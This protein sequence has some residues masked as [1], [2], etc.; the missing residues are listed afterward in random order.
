MGDSEP[1]NLDQFQNLN[2]FDFENIHNSQSSESGDED[3]EF[4]PKHDNFDLGSNNL[5]D[6]LLTKQVMEIGQHSLESAI[7]GSKAAGGKKVE[8]QKGGKKKGKKRSKKGKSQ[9][10]S[11]DDASKSQISNTV[12]EMDSIDQIQKSVSDPHQYKNILMKLVEDLLK[13]ENAR[14]PDQS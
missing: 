13:F 1:T 2:Q 4:K 8:Q 7:P 14:M 6:D 12:E 5:E 9:R 10:K 11:H 3:E